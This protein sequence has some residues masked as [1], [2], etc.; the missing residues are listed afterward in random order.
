MAV[1]EE[2]PQGNPLAAVAEKTPVAHPV[3]QRAQKT[4]E[5]AQGGAAAAAR[6]KESSSSK[7]QWVPE[8]AAGTPG[9]HIGAR[10]DEGREG[11]TPRQR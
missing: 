6:V 9:A 8:A 3:R 2:R 11:W 10:G 7:C 1:L 4:W 5:H